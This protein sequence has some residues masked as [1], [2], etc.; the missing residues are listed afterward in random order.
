MAIPVFTAD[1]IE[2]IARCLADA[3]THAQFTGLFARLDMNAPGADQGAKWHRIREALLARQARDR[4]GNNVGTFIQEV[5]A[6][7]NFVDGPEAFASLRVA[8]NRI[9]A[10][11]GLGID[12]AGTLGRVVAARTLDE[13]E[14]RAN[15][16]RAK[17]T[18]R[19]V[20][21]DV[22][23]FCRPELL[24]GN[25]FHAVLEATKS[26]GDKVRSRSTLTGDGAEL[27]QR[28]FCGQEPYLA[29]NSLRTE[30]ERSEQ[31]GFANLVI[32]L[33]GTFRNP[34]AHAPRVQWPVSEQD[35]LDLLTLVSYVHRRLDAAVR[36]HH[37][38]PTSP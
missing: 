12:E 7:V 10:F 23:A 19:S 26:V 14:V 1:Q 13:A 22:L 25:Y 8:L 2:Q 6:P 17:L 32:G 9:L 24:N 16:L 20:H 30:T 31:T 34:T 11:S 37:H 29:I 4:V 28:A 35:A 33:F 18:A 21:P 38:R 27:I 5:M 3:R 36:T 15:E